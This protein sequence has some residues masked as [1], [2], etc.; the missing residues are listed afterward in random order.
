MKVAVMRWRRD[1]DDVERVTVVS[2]RGGDMV[3]MDVGDEVMVTAVGGRDLAKKERKASKI[4][5]EG[6][7]GVECVCG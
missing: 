7:E 1:E 5:K 2:E 4:I 3:E 6:G